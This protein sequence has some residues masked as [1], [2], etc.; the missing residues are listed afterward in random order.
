MTELALF[1]RANQ[2]D[3]GFRK[4]HDAPEVRLICTRHPMLLEHGKSQVPKECGIYP[5]C[6]AIYDGFLLLCFFTGKLGA[7]RSPAGR[8]G[9]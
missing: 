5:F 6:S 9:F 3:D 2:R 7:L 8:G 1:A 4:E